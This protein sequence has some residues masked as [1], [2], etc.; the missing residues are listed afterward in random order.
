MIKLLNHFPKRINIYAYLIT[1]IIFIELKYGLISFLK[2]DSFLGRPGDHFSGNFW[3]A[4]SVSNNLSKVF[5]NQ[6]INVNAGF[7]DGI[8]YINGLDIFQVIPKILILFLSVVFNPIVASNLY[9]LLGI[10]TTIISLYFLS[11]ELSHNTLQAIIFSFVILYSPYIVN[12]RDIH[13]NYAWIFW[14]VLSLTIIL[15]SSKMQIVNYR[16][17]FG[18]A[19]VTALSFYFDVYNILIAIPL[20]ITFIILILN[21]NKDVYTA[22]IKKI[23]VLLSLLSLGLLPQYIFANLFVDLNSIQRSKSDFFGFQFSFKNL[24]IYNPGDILN[25]LFSFLYSEPILTTDEN[26]FGYRLTVLAIILLLFVYGFLLRKTKLNS[27]LPINLYIFLLVTVVAILLSISFSFRLYNLEINSPNYYFFQFFPYFRVFSR[28]DVLLVITLPAILIAI[29]QL[30][31]NL[32]IPNF[33][34]LMSLLVD[35]YLLSAE[36]HYRITANEI[37][38]VYQYISQNTKKSS[39]IY[40]VEKQSFDANF[41]GW[42]YFHER[43]LSNLSRILPPDYPLSP[44]D[45]GAACIFRSSGV[46]YVLMRKEYLSEFRESELLGFISSDFNKLN[47]ISDFFLFE[48]QKGKSLS[49]VYRLRPISDRFETDINRQTGLWTSNL[50]TDFAFVTNSKEDIERNKLE[51][52]MNLSSL[53]TND[54]KIIV[55]GI[56]NSRLI[57]GPTPTKVTLSLEPQDIVTLISRN[58]VKPSDLNIGS[59]DERSLGVFV[60]DVAVGSC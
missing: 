52:S 12:K 14:L 40:F 37:D 32:R 25:S 36:P 29:Y 7:P 1:N 2:P 38:P 11:R 59:R 60:S 48:V 16:L 10:I 53:I 45:P 23:V 39:V 21:R 9:L 46:D 35:S 13:P 41:L 54:L 8:N 34:L 27:Y 55:N 43:K 5:S 51:V 26:V 22:R 30:I 28:I 56:E 42:Q 4:Y 58:L 47:E 33:L 18:F 17:I 57:L 20:C 50:T 19:A 44:F 15:R 6:N 24:T 49:N 31:P 3:W